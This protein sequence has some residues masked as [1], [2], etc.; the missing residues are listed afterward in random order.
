[1]PAF[2]R[3]AV[4]Y[5][6]YFCHARGG[7]DLL[8]VAPGLRQQGASSSPDWAQAEITGKACNKVQM[9]PVVLPTLGRS[10]QV[11]VEHSRLDEGWPIR[12]FNLDPKLAVFGPADEGL[13]CRSGSWWIW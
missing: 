12:Y 2:G 6:G 1:M 8:P 4:T 7:G 10:Q 9:R 11:H 13:H 3:Q 5:S